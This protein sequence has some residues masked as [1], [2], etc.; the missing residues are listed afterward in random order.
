MK[1]YTAR[2]QR[3]PR[4]R[5]GSKWGKLALS[6]ASA[7]VGADTSQLSKDGVPQRVPDSFLLLILRAEYRQK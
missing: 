3:V 7:L 2:L 6:V 4:M 1:S 5:I